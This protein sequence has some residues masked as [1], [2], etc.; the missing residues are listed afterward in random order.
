MS[1]QTTRADFRWAALK[2]GAVEAFHDEDDVGPFD[3]VSGNLLVRI[4]SQTSGCDLG[5]GTKAKIGSG[6]GMSGRLQ[7]Q[8]KMLVGL[9][10][11]SA[12][13]DGSP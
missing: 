4:G 13:F 11:V 3:Q 2:F 9:C 7:N 10:A 1:R 6:A 8:R 5:G 12:Q